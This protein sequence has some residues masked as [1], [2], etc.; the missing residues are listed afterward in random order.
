MEV[1]IAL[2][3]LRRKV[4]RAQFQRGAHVIG[5]GAFRVGPGDE[6]HAPAA[7]LGAVEHLGAYAVLLHGALEE[8]AQVVVSYLSQK[9]GR[10]AED[11]G[12]GDGVGGGATRNILYAILFEG[13]PDTVSGFHVHMLHAAQRK[14]ILFQEAVVRQDGQDVGKGIPNS[15]DRFHTEKF[16]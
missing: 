11:G 9:A 15:Q 13:F 5:K 4:F 10:H 1:V 8:V 6:H 14:M 12:A 2:E 3:L 16:Y 7:G